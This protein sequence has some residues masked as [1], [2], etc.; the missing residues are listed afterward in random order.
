MIRHIFKIIRNERKTNS[1][2]IL[3]YVIVFC[4]LWFCCDY[5]YYIT[6]CSYEP[7]GFDIDHTYSIRMTERY[8]NEADPGAET[9]NLT[10][11]EKYACALTLIERLKRYPEIESISLS[12]AGM[13]Y[14]GS[15][16]ISSFVINADSTSLMIQNRFVSSGFFDVFRIKLVDGYIFDWMDPAN[17]NFILISPDR[18]DF[19]GNP[20][21]SGYPVSDVHELKHSY[22]S[23]KIFKV[24]GVTE[25]LKSRFFDPYKN[26]VF[27]SLAVR[28]VDLLRIEIT[29]RT[30]PNVAKGFTER[31][32]KN[33][34]EQLYIGPYMFSNISSLKDMQKNS[35]KW[36]GVTDNLNSIYAIT[37][38]LIINIF[39]GVIGTFWYR[40]ESRTS[41][42][43]LRIA[44]GSS[45]R[46]IK[47]LLY[48]ETL[49]LLF[50][51]AVI[52]VNICINIGQ[53]DLLNALGIPQANSEQIGS[54][55][56]QYFINFGVTV[57]FLAIISVL[58]VWYP[59][60]QASNM[61]P[62][63]ALHEE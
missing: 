60:G 54:G 39:L 33:M 52:G 62:A 9:G 61:H 10:R 4:I 45:R 23:D 8:L 28:D 22:K 40:T 16:S 12:E 15:V 50:I 63:E 59:A 17:E 57:L 32:V 36:S 19:F 51:S 24:I 6:K 48:T 7:H 53:T 43:G 44:L 38:F 13:P 5:L 58:A 18:N 37:L 49:F 14:S 55:V 20:V 2:I 41:D 21:K 46:K 11:D 56:E 42:I 29:I 27:H 25:K 26:T 1:W 35:M 47:T 3:E 34:K 30:H 31:F